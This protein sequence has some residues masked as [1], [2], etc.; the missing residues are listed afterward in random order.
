MSVQYDRYAQAALRSPDSALPDAGAAAPV[1]RD[2]DGGHLAATW[3][4]SVDGAK[5]YPRVHISRD[6]TLTMS[7]GVKLRATVVR[8]ANRLGQPSRG[9]FP[10]VLNI[11]PYNRAVI[12]GIDHLLHSPGI[13]RA[14]RAA[15]GTMTYEHGPLTGIS[16]LTRTFNRGLW[17]VFG[18]N[19]NLVQSGYVQV[20]VDVR[21]TGAS[22]G[23]WEILGEREQRDSV[24]I[25]EWMAR[26]NW[27]DGA[28]GMAGW[29][30]S[31][32]NSLQA[33]GHRPDALKAI[34]AV[35][36]SGDVVRDIYIT[37]GMPSSFIPVWMSLVNLAKW[38]PNPATVLID[39]LRGDQIR[40]LMDR[41][42]SP[43]TELPSLLWGFLTARDDRIFD[44]PYFEVRAP[45][46]AD[47]DAATFTVGGWHD[48]FGRSAT[49]IYSQLNMAPGRKQTLIANGY[50]LDPGCDH[51]GEHEPPRLDVLERAWFDKWLKDIPNGVE[52]YGPV[53]MEQQGGDWSCGP[54]FPRPEVRTQ[55]LFLTQDATDTAPHARHDGALA[56]SP[57]TRRRSLRTSPDLRGMMS[58][59][60][61]QVLAGIPI[62]FGRNFTDDARFQEHG[63]L[64]FT[65]EPVTAPTQISGAMNLR[66]N[67]STNA[68]EGIWAVTVNDVAPDGT[69]TVLTNGALT[70]SNRALDTERSGYTEEG[71]LIDAVHYLSRER[72]LAVPADEPV[73][74]D[75]DLVA[76]DAVLA[77]GHRLRVDVY[78]A[79]LP[80][81]LTIVPDLIKARG[82]RQHLVLD[83]NKPSYLSF[84]S[85]GDLGADPV[86]A[87]TQLHPI[88]G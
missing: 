22:H 60:M 44:D 55:R 26:Q 11:N 2:A 83:P 7:D 76:T 37:G 54:Q 72:R 47:I 25:I 50:H 43:A 79:S 9:R 63:A 46:I 3:R 78:A 74:I 4:E 6:V 38:L 84:L 81:Y 62:V 20:L 73:R 58:R 36:G 85:D 13:G 18:I 30:Y 75:V 57:S 33:A 77:P 27:C 61:S 15:S 12:D 53:T 45:K 41:V 19:R 70:A 34:F 23:K 32:I 10:G 88:R 24:E 21:G 59:D 82:R 87:A 14:T 64:S 71:V 40:W 28:V 29:S 68:H 5:P 16:R 35:E 17:D 49:R 86:P 31:A 80:R 8:P 69:S 66:L 56:T 51:G 52:T 67:V 65:S 1:Y 42:K 39:T 48:L